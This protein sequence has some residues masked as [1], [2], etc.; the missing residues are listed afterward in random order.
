LADGADRDGRPPDIALAN[1]YAD[2][3]LDDIG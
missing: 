3:H 2:E 1:V